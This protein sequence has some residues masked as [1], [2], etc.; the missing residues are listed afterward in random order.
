VPK[1]LIP[2]KP[3]PEG[4]YASLGFNKLQRS[5]TLEQQAFWPF[6]SEPEIKYEWFEKKII[7]SL[8]E[9]LGRDY[10]TSVRNA[11]EQVPDNMA[12]RSAFLADAIFARNPETAETRSAKFAAVWDV[13]WH[14][15]TKMCRYNAR[16]APFAG[17]KEK[18]DFNKKFFEYLDRN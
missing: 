6:I 5:E 12:R 10:I 4:Y 1:D 18:S 3:H 11:K 7:K 17:Q 14:S 2:F 9:A 8:P 13:L 16:I 15:M